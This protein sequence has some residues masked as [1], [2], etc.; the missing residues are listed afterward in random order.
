M[1]VFGGLVVAAI[2]AMAAPARAQLAGDIVKG[3]YGLA[4][5]SQPPEGLVLSAFAYDY[6]TTTIKGPNGN[7][8]PTSGHL[9]TLA[10]PGLN[11]WWVSPWKVLG[12]N[13]GAVL[14]LWGTRAAVDAPRLGMSGS[15]YGFGDMYIKPIEL[16]WHT[17]Y[18]DAI[19]GLAFYLPTGRYSPGANDNTGQGQWGF[20]P[21]AGATLWPDGKHHFNLATQVF[22][23]IYSERRGTVPMTDAHLKTGN[24]LTL[25]SGLGYQLLGG[26]L[27]VGIPY[28]AQWKVTNDTVPIGG[29]VLQG[30]VAA[31]DWSAGIG[32]EVDFNWNASNGV[33]LRWLQGLGGANT[34]IGSTFF[35]AYNHVFNTPGSK[36]PGGS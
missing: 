20:E 28:F 25:Q 31:K 30:I 26:G 22:Y 12:A 13:Y 15:T 32:A 35:A 23:D 21:S 4:T 29:P 7:T 9:N 2:I 11:L 16:G 18:V 14:T 36:P 3:Q 5:G 6:Y 34:S 27:N 17:T 10:I 24:I 19:A 1:K 8:L 33:T